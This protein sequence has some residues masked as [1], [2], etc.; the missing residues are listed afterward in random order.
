MDGDDL[1]DLP[2][3]DGAGVGGGLHRADIATDHDGDQPAADL[4]T[5]DE[6][7]VGGL[8]HG[9]G[10]LDGAHQPPGLDQAEGTDGDA[11]T[12]GGRRA[13]HLHL[14]AGGMPVAG[15]AHR[16][17]GGPGAR[18]RGA[19]GLTAGDGVTAVGLGPSDGDVG[20]GAGAF[21]RNHA[22]SCSGLREGWH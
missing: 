17:G 14:F 8:D 16:L 22:V 20:D 9:V 3:G 7:D 5:P 6:A 10:G 19:T 18:A 1:A 11:M 12:V 2:G 21:L 4:L 13:H 15:L